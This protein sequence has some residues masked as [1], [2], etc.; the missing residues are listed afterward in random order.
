MSIKIL[1]RK[2]ERLFPSLKTGNSNAEISPKCK[3]SN[4]KCSITDHS[5]QV[6]NYSEID[7]MSTSESPW[8]IK[9]SFSSFAS[10]MSE[11]VEIEKDMIR[12]LLLIRQETE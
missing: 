7:S 6:Q 12:K 4:E 8:S 9:H 5:Q 1:Q 10:S 3:N 2:G 11:S